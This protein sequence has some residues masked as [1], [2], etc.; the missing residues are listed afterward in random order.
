MPDAPEIGGKVAVGGRSFRLLG[1]EPYVR[2]DGRA[3]ELLLW[4]GACTVCGAA[5]Y[6]KSGPWPKLVNLNAVRCMPHRT[7]TT[8]QEREAISESSRQ[9]REARPALTDLL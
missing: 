7:G 8:E 6:L 3:T 1:R 2:K 4:Q 9:R 5:F